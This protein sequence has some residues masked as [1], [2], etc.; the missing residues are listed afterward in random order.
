MSPDIASGTTDVTQCLATSYTCDIIDVLSFARKILM[1]FVAV[2]VRLLLIVEWLTTLRAYISLIWCDIFKP[3]VLT[4]TITYS[5]D[6]GPCH[7]MTRNTRMHPSVRL[8]AS[9]N[10]QHAPPPPPTC[11]GGVTS[12]SVSLV[13]AKLAMGTRGQFVSV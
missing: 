7:G 2:S 10:P 12:V 8:S 1:L 5:G 11:R 3:T 6:V 13:V 4:T 9:P